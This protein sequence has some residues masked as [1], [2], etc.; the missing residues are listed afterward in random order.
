MGRSLGAAGVGKK[1]IIALARWHFDSGDGGED[2]C[3]LS[4]EAGEDGRPEGHRCEACPYRK[5]APQTDDGE[6]V[7]EVVGAIGNQLRVAGM[8]AVYG[9]D[10]GAALALGQ[11]F[12][13]P[14]E[15][16]ADVLPAV[17]TVLVRRASGAGMDEGDELGD[18]PAQGEHG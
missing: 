15:L 6:A 13:A 18:A 1:R 5:H 7:W 17:E 14:S 4:C 9:L 2:Y 8:G 3:R 16:L 12:G 11:A 10:F